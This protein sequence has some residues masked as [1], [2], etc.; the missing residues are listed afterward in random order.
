MNNKLTKKL[1]VVNIII[2]LLSTNIILAYPINKPQKYNENNINFNKKNNDYEKRISKINNKL[3]FG[4]TLNVGGSGEGNYT[5]IQDA[6]NDAKDNDSW[7]GVL[8]GTDHTC[9]NCSVGPDWSRSHMNYKGHSLVADMVWYFLKGWDYNTTYTGGNHSLYVDADYNQT[10]HINNSDVFDVDT[11]SIT[12]INNDSAIDYRI[13]SGFW[14]PEV[15]RFGVHKGM[16]YLITDGNS[17]SPVGN[18]TDICGQQNA[19]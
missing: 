13:Q 1:I 16:G 15:I 10:I 3:N 18:F 17:S 9:Y 8:D 2:I 14:R 6:I 11:L 19:L 4:E 5:K 12:C 7:N